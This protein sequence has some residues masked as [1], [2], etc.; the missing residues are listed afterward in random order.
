[1]AFPRKQPERTLSAHIP[2]IRVYPEE[3]EAIKK[4]AK[5]QH[6][7]LSELLRPIILDAIFHPP[8]LILPS[9]DPFQSPA[10]LEAISP[11]EVD[12]DAAKKN[13]RESKKV[14]KKIFLC[15][16]NLPRPNCAICSA[17]G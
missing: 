4:A 14:S 3:F 8:N 2:K 11:F 5:R 6:C 17:M 12:S 15:P 16:H 7:G 13:R 9:P 1:M 10:T